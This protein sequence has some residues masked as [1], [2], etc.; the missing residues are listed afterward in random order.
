MVVLIG[1]RSIYCSVRISRCSPE[2]Y[3]IVKMRCLHR[4]IREASGSSGSAFPSFSPASRTSQNYNDWNGNQDFFRYT[5]GRFLFEETKQMACR[6]I[7]FNMNELVHIAARSI[8]SKSCVAVHKLPEGQHSKAFLLTMDDGKR[9]V[10]KIPNP[11]AG[12]PHY[13]TASE[14]ATLDFVSIGSRYDITL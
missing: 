5:A 12:R 1:F 7:Q 4:K 11:N 9:V 2:R 8:A 6:Y 14:V 10:A 13:T 3:S